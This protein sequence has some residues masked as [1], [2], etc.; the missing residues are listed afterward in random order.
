MLGNGNPVE[1]GIEDARRI[2]D[3]LFYLG[4][5]ITDIERFM[6]NA[7]SDKRRAHLCLRR[8]PQGVMSE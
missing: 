4:V 6:W 5:D 8:R 3:E 7:V 1:A 2:V